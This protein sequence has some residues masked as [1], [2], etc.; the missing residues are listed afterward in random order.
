MHPL[1]VADAGA[2]ATDDDM[3]AAAINLFMSVPGTNGLAS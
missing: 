1:A 2:N 3:M